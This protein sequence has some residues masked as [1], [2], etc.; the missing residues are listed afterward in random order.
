MRRRLSLLLPLFLAACDARRTSSSADLANWEVAATTL[1]A[2][3]DKEDADT[4]IF[5]RVDDARWHA[6]TKR[7]VVADGGAFGLRVYDEAGQLVAQGGRRG[8]GPGEF[9]GRLA[10]A[11]AAG[12]SVAVWDSGQGR[13]TLFSVADGGMRNL[14]GDQSSVAWMYGGML[15]RSDVGSPPGWVPPLLRALG[16][17]AGDTRLVRLDR[18]ALALVSQDAALRT[19]HVHRDSLGPIA[20][21]ALPAGLQVTD[22]DEEV[23][24]GVRADSL[25]LEQVAV[26]RLTRGAHEAPDRTP[27]ADPAPP[28]AERNELMSM[29]RNAVVAQEMNYAQRNSYTAHG[30]SLAVAAPAG[31]RFRILEATARGWSGVVWVPA[32]GYTCGMIIGLTTPPGWMEGEARCGWR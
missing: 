18:S 16:D 6:A 11:P 19:W 30:D 10:L 1:L 3:G 15:V 5:F 2:V 27:A 14:T 9:A 4:A 23:I 17:S 28:E 8:R 21:I 31:A 20:T 7:L 25:G 13:W 32:T 29:L 12:D 26:H 22:F 24:V